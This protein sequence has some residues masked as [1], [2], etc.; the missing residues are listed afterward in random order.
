MTGTSRNGDGNGG[1]GPRIGGLPIDD[2]PFEIAELTREQVALLLSE[3]RQRVVRQLDRTPG[4]NVTTLGRKAGLPRS[5]ARFHVGKLRR[6][7]LVVVKKG[8][9]GNER[10]CF[11]PADAHLWENPKTR[12]LFGGDP[13]RNVALYIAEHPGARVEE[14]GEAVGRDPR[15]VYHHLEKLE[16]RSLVDSVPAGRGSVYHPEP[17]LCE[18]EQA[19]GKGFERP[20]D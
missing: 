6:A 8:V 2:L 17:E 15:T 4:V 11:L 10:V 7:E 13:T 5:V 19:A 1:G 9:E 18:W 12:V 3:R 14:I 20:W 16:D